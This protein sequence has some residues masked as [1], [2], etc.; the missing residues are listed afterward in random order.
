M[1]DNKSE[2]RSIPRWA[3]TCSGRYAP[4]KKAEQDNDA[5]RHI[6]S[7]NFA[8]HGRGDSEMDHQVPRSPEPGRKTPASTEKRRLEAVK[9]PLRGRERW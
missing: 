6:I 4:W 3:H 1:V 9:T 7:M 5:A 2:S 8:E